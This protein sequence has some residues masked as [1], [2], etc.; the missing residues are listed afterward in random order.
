MNKIG[1]RKAYSLYLDEADA[2]ALQ[3]WLH[4]RGM[5]ADMAEMPVERPKPDQ[6]L[7]AVL[8]ALPQSFF[9]I[10]HDFRVL[11]LN[12][13]A[14][15][16]S[17]KLMGNQVQ[18][19]D[20]VFPV[21]YENY[22]T[23]FTE[24]GRKALGG[25]A[26]Y[27]ERIFHIEGQPPLWLGVDYLPVRN[28][29]GKIIAFGFSSQNITIR[30][31]LEAQLRESEADLRKLL[32]SLPMAAALIGEGSL[33]LNA[34]AQEMMPA[35]E[36]MVQAPETWFASLFGK[37]KDMLHKLFA[38]DL[39]SESPRTRV[40]QLTRADGTTRWLE[41]G[42]ATVGN[43]ILCI[44]Y[45]RT[46]QQEYEEQLIVSNMRLETILLM[47]PIA[48]IITGNNKITFNKA[49]ETITGWAPQEI[50]SHED[51]QRKL[52]GKDYESTMELYRSRKQANFK[53]KTVVKA[54]HKDGHEIYLKGSAILVGD[55]VVA[56]F[57]DVTEDILTRHKLQESEDRFRTIANSTMVMMW[58]SDANK[59]CTF[60][61]KAWLDFT[62]RTLEEELGYGWADNVHPEDRERSVETYNANFDQRK[63]FTMEY[64]LRRHDGLWRWVLDSGQPRFSPNGTFLGFTGNCIDITEMH[65]ATHHSEE[66]ALVAQYTNNGVIITDREGYTLWAN[67]AMEVIS[68]YD[69]HELM[70]KKPGDVLQGAD[71]DPAAVLLIS[72]ALKKGVAIRKEI[73]NYHKDGTPYWIDLH[74][75]PVKDPAGRVLKFI[76]IENEITETVR[77]RSSLD[78]ALA[79]LQSFKIAM[80]EVAMLT[81][82]NREGTIVEVNKKE[83]DITGY[84]EQELVGQD[85]RKMQGDYHAATYWHQIWTSLNRKQVW[86]GEMRSRSKYGQT[87]HTD[88]TIVPMRD[89]RG[90]ISQYL[91]IRYDITER[92]LVQEAL[93]VSERELQQAI[94]AA[95]LGIWHWHVDTGNVLINDEL[96][97]VLT[98]KGATLLESMDLFQMMIDVEDRL[99]FRQILEAVYQGQQTDKLI[100]IRF[101]AADGSLLW[102]LQSLFVTRYNQD[103]MPSRITGIV[104]DITKEKLLAEERVQHEIDLLSAVLKGQ[105]AERSRL[106]TELHDS[107]GTLL[108]AVGMNF[109]ALES[110]LEQNLAVQPQ[111]LINIRDIINEAVQ[112]TRNISHNLN[113]QTLS[114]H[115]LKASLEALIK[116]LE[117]SKKLEVE[118]QLCPDIQNLNESDA[119]SIYR[120]V[121]E[122]LQNT[123]K[124]AQAQ[125]LSISIQKKRNLMTLTTVDDGQGFD[126]KQVKM[127][128]GL[129][130]IESRVRLLNG[131]MKVE[132][133]SGKGTKIVVKFPY[134][135]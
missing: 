4:E 72:E 7:E 120:I 133:Q 41:Y 31:Q 19:G 18:P 46:E 115:G 45:D 5:E 116:R 89:N 50:S 61:N 124:H 110:K 56:L 76:A 60:L 38:D 106:A 1:A 99:A 81:T 122:V 119:L 109:S 2:A 39:R 127:G 12:D 43:K 104:V 52:Y 49:V 68:G 82:M 62:G 58:V 48:A 32:F 40:L 37:H 118:M 59:E 111:L 73:L 15:Y 23:A 57:D 8:N 6:M 28:A 105:D 30:K 83:C 84:S 85:Y 107:L 13:Q 100:E 129:H 86:H 33:M 55:E 27:S 90:D 21:V 131:Q 87:L 93:R 103:G 96:M 22:L 25:E 44:L 54:Y 102:M 123:L 70:G 24:N 95:H 71:T 134:V 91:V 78:K 113:P 34:K 135:H 75:S 108:S 121:Q 17:E 80:D 42:A 125:K 9:L 130:N 3:Q 112:E 20:S 10:D 16:Y 53:G 101:R 11:T 117:A 92:K 67:T 64:R 79:S 74:I 36:E 77:L 63:T 51:W 97:Q 66:L 14:R 88:T 26:I 65:E 98:G 35:S 132:S 128:M 114:Q 94:S 29:D 126:Q 47:L 69:L